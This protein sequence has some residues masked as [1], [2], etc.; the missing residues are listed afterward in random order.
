MKANGPLR[1]T[2]L[3]RLGEDNSSFLDFHILASMD[4][5]KT[6]DLRL[7]DSWLNRGQRLG[8]LLSFCTLVGDVA[9][10]SA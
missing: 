4:R 10:P 7:T 9:Q 1:T 8:D 3:A 5:V 6:F 2:L